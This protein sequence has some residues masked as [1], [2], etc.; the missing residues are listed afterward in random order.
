MWWSKGILVFSYNP[1]LK[2][3]PIRKIS[4]IIT[5][6]FSTPHSQNVLEKKAREGCWAFSSNTFEKVRNHRKTHSNKAIVFIQYG[7]LPIKGLP[8]CPSFKVSPVKYHEH[9]ESFPGVC[10][11]H[12]QVCV[13]TSACMQAYVCVCVQACL[14]V[15]MPRVSTLSENVCMHTTIPP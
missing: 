3:V 9:Q 7:V 8:H 14:C 5:F 13:C 11:A 1:V 15:C 6:W 2:I 10:R 4:V 12:T